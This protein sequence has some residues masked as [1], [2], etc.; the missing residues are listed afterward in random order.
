MFAEAHFLRCFLCH[1]IVVCVLT[2]RTSH[3][4]DEERWFRTRRHRRLCY[5]FE[6]VERAECEIVRKSSCLDLDVD[7]RS[8]ATNARRS[9]SR[10]CCGLKAFDQDY[11]VTIFSSIRKLSAEH[12]IRRE[13]LAPGV[14]PRALLMCL[15]LEP[16]AL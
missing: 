1:C 3:F 12:D 7:S 9:P 4:G 2:D 15:L 11:D 5:N 6:K 13:S 16:L 10:K 8:R 14:C